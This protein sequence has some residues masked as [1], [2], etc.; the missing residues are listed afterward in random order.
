MV[1]QVCSHLDP[2]SLDCLSF[3]RA[4][5]FLTLRLPPEKGKY[6]LNFILASQSPRRR[7]I[8]KQIGLTNLFIR[9]I[10]IEESIF[11]GETPSGAVLRLSLEKAR[12]AALDAS[13]DDVII[14]ADTIVYAGGDIIGKPRD[15]ADAVRM[16]KLLSN[17]THEVYTGL[18]VIFRGEESQCFEKTLVSFN[19]LTDEEISLYLETG[20]SFDKAGA[21]GI[22]AMGSLFV[23]VIEGNFYNVMGLPVA[24]LYSLLKQIN[25]NLFNYCAPPGSSPIPQT[26]SSP[27]D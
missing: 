20:E 19:L 5:S 7:D 4:A 21:Y 23:S 10:D 3:P 9:P 8:L 16:L 11:R 17:S 15:R 12:H 1:P 27:A 13:S 25:I 18:S 14:A 24:K 22:Q 26:F 2:G 6:Q